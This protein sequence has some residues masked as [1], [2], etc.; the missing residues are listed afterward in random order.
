MKII[1]LLFNLGILFTAFAF[2][3]FWLKFFLVFLVPETIRTRVRY[4]LQLLQSLFLGALV[5]RFLK[6]EG[7]DLNVNPYVVIALGTY[8]LYLIRNIHSEKR[9]VQIQVYSNLY[10]QLKTKNDWEWTVAF[11]SLGLTV[12]SIAFPST[13]DGVASAW[14][15]E[16]TQ[17]IIEMPFLGSVFKILGFFFILGLAFRMLRS[18][19]N[20][21]QPKQKEKPEG[22]DDF[23]EV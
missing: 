12:A 6:E 23:E 22:F 20:L 18:I 14:F 8:F 1:T 10:K 5:L 2:L 16:E 9:M 19:Q 15:Y 11:V 4:F 7:H 21:L 3:W 17:G 13:I